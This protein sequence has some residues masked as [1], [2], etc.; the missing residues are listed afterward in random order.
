MTNDPIRTRA[1][2]ERTVRSI[3]PPDASIRALADA[4]QA[5]LT[6][7]PGSLGFLEEIAAR[8]AAIQRSLSPRV[9]ARTVA[10]FAADHGVTAEGVSPYPSEVTAQMVANFLAGGGA[11][12][13]IARTI[14][15]DVI[16]VD[17]G[18]RSSIEPAPGL[19]IRKIANGTRN[20]ARERAMTEDQ[21]LAA[22][23]VGMEVASKAAASGAEVIVLGEMG[24]GNTTSAS[25]IAAALTRRPA[26]VVTGRGTGLDDEAVA[27][28]AAV[29]ERALALHASA[30]GSPLGILECVGGFE[31]GAICG[32]CLGAA[33][34]GTLVVVDGFIST[35]GAALAAGIAPTAREYMIAG[36]RSVEP[37]HRALLDLLGLRPIL[38]LDMRLGE[39]TGA[40]L[41]VPVI[42]GA[43]ATFREMATFESAG[44]SD[45]EG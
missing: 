17:A 41:A 36:H 11:I 25:A 19:L 12:N 15:A 35:A 29:V 13:A 28:K 24:I 16:V 6:K 26:T 37:G 3:E 20:F 27:R 23:A 10:V 45:R 34:Y 32:A 39:G 30:I 22:V 2:V 40:A 9:D 7:P 43:V 44:V 21:A 31:I 5:R 8:V 38:E 33:A 42:A 18:V 4:R 1:L 14:S